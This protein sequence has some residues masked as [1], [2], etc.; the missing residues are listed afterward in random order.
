LAP[1]AVATI[2]V[3]LLLV[4]ANVIIHYEFLRATS[5]FANSLTIQRRM[6]ILVVLTGVRLAPLSCDAP[7]RV[8]RVVCHEQRSLCVNGNAYGTAGHHAA[9]VILQEAG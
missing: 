2:A 6:H 3:A 9:S 5:A 7:D 4:A 1:L 8:A